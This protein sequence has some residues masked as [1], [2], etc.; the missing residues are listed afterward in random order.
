VNYGGILMVFDRLFGTY[1]SE[2][3]DVKIRYGLVEPQLS[4]NPFKILFSQWVYLMRDVVQSK[5]LE[6]LDPLSQTN[7]AAIATRRPN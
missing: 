6:A 2:R 7:Q 5:S 3:E 1:R 4:N